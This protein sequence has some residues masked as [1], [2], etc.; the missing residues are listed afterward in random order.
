VQWRQRDNR[1]LIS[2]PGQ[3]I[4]KASFPG[5]GWGENSPA[6]ISQ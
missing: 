4:M 3:A 2:K 5:D 1:P 6:A